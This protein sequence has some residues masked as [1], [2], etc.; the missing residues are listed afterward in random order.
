MADAELRSAV[1][2]L[3]NDVETLR[4]SLRMYPESHPALEPARERIRLRAAEVCGEDAEGT[5]GLAPEKVFWNGEDIELTATYPAARLTQFL[6][7][8]GIAAIR[9]TFPQAGDGLASLSA[10]LA[11]LHD[12]PG[13]KERSQL[14]EGAAALAGL[15]LVP[16]DL[17]SVQP[18]L[19][20]GERSS[21]GSRMVLAELAR[22]LS[23][24]GAFPLAGMIH[25]GELTPG[26]L[27]ELLAA[28]SDPEML[29]DHAFLSLG[30][31]LRS[32]SP[33]RRSPVLNEV[34]EFLVDLLRLLDP[35]R[36]K[37]AVA[38][39]LRH[40]PVVGDQDQVPWV[41]AEL[42]LDAVEFM[43]ISQAPIPEAVHRAL[44]RMAAPLAEQNPPL[45]ESLTARAR[46]LLAQ[47]PAATHE[48]EFASP[49]AA[50]ALAVDWEGASWV[51]DLAASLTE[52][53]VRLHVVRLL[54]ETITAWPGQPVADRAAVRLAEE[55]AAALDI[56]DLATAR[57][58]AGMLASTRSADA[59]RVVCET[60]VPA[61]V[62]AFATIDR[63]LHPDLTAV[64]VSLGE[65]ALP[66]ILE[67]MAEEKS[68]V[69]RKRLLEVVARHGD[70]AKPYLHPLLDDPRWYVVRNAVFL[71]RRIG[72]H[73]IVP[74]LKTHLATARPQVLA[75]MLK[76]LVASED[77]QWFAVLMR[78]ID[79]D[80][81]ERRRVALEVASR[82]GNPHVVRA[83]LQR[84]QAR[85]GL[86]L[87]EPLSIELIR[88]LGRLRDPM[89]LPLLRDILGLKQ[90]RF[91]FPLTAVRREAAV[92][93]ASINDAEARRLALALANDRDPEVANAV[94]QAL[95]R[96][97]E[98]EE[99]E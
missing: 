71:L 44:H 94:R 36:A 87:R 12:P 43:L 73:E 48:A 80:D 89:A 85:V 22:R 53:Q 64:L 66:A 52:E 35:E 26:M 38:V 98:T 70:R 40:L 39:A 51:G 1:V 28:A 9:L 23:R 13:E 29:F 6:F 31:I 18:S 46:Q 58:V 93:L 59:H 60:G 67:A 69:V 79:S 63:E 81:E 91:P 84:L 55:F 95:H 24:D 74:V 20:E 25:E 30:E 78:T 14:M 61:A 97:P 17:S 42:L 88:A 37:L 41:A 47:I 16:I 45:A 21:T 27:A 75:E 72:G 10:H 32:A 82:I 65:G 4:R 83:L 2:R 62:R 86:R 99:I 96:K 56:G 34:R 92:A 68:L 3:L 50:S 54:Q 5:L 11:T 7:H 19:S 76:A 33:S 8:L 15:E 90:W 49:L 77:P 57:H